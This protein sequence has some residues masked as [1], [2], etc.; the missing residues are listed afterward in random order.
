MGSAV[1]ESTLGAQILDDELSLLLAHCGFEQ[2]TNTNSSYSLAQLLRL[3]LVFR[4][5]CMGYLFPKAGF[6]S[7]PSLGLTQPAS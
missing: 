7:L 6:L 4:N 5:R 3:R 2:G 1:V